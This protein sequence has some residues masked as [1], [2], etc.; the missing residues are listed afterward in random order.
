M[1]K[2]KNKTI[3]IVCHYASLY[4]GNFI[5]SLIALANKLI[6]NYR[7]IFT[8][9]LEAKG[10]NWSEFMKQNGLT[11]LFIDFSKGFRKQIKRINKINNVSVVYTHFIS[12]LRTK[13]LY[14]FSKRIKLLI[15]IHSDFSGG[16]K[17]SG[18][19]KIKS[20]IEHRV[21]R[22]DAKYIFVS[23]AMYNKFSLK[24][25]YFY[26]Q[27]A[28]ALERIPSKEN[29]SI[30]L[31]KSKISNKDTVF[32]TFAWSPYVKGIE[33]LTDEILL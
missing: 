28:L 31:A 23:E 26:I 5:P 4:G 2:I 33:V 13:S 1:G 11:V 6:I 22:K 15:H 20:F 27:N 14:P 19:S 29:S 21:L 12:G 3:N 30:E 8:F 10:R 7:V 18:F 25:N 24:D 9:P 17:Q 16:S 32:L